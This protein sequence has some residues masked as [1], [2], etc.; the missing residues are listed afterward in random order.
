VASSRRSRCDCP[1]PGPWP[2][3]G[4]PRPRY[5][6]QRQ[7]SRLRRPGR[8]AAAIRR[9]RCP[10]SPAGAIRRC[11][12]PRRPDGSTRPRQPGGSAIRRCPVRRPGWASRLLRR[13]GRRPGWASRLLRRAGRRPGWA[14]RLLRRGGR[15]PGWGGRRPFPATRRRW[16]RARRRWSATRRQSQATP[17]RSLATRSGRHRPRCSPARCAPP[18]CSPPREPTG[19]GPGSAASPGRGSAARTTRGHRRHP[20][21]RPRLAA[22]PRSARYR[23]RPPA[24]ST[25]Y[26]GGV[27]R[28]LGCP[29]GPRPHHPDSPCGEGIVA[30]PL[31]LAGPEFSLPRV[32]PSG[33][34]RRSA[35]GAGGL[36]GAPAG[37]AGHPSG[38]LI[39]TAAS[40]GRYPTETSTCFCMSAV[41]ARQGRSRG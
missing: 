25:A 32:Q 30:L 38:P 37:G 22:Y 11:R 29:A 16:G 31:S 19:P 17:G 39:L 20:R 4:H 24:Q 18:R 21:T 35:G 40:R 14:S 10:G 26:R 3:A 2:R 15:G 28:P 9:C 6:P 23:P 1:W 8:P 34:W 36:P 12:C 33:R 41:P 13:A 7:S 27:A 5:P